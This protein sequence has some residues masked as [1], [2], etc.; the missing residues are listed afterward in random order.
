MLSKLPAWAIKTIH[1]LF[2]VLLVFGGLGP[3][4][5][6]LAGIVPAPAL[7]VVMRIVGVCSGIG[8]WI[9]AHRIPIEAFLGLP[10]G[11]LAAA[12]AKAAA[13]AVGVV[14]AL[15]VVLALYLTGCT[16]MAPIVPQTPDNAAQISSCQ[17]LSGAHND[18]VV[19]GFV[20]GLS[21]STLA[22]IAAGEAASNPSLG[23]DLGIAATATGAVAA[24]ALV[25]GSYYANGYAAQRC[26]DVMGPLPI[27]PAKTKP[28]DP[29]TVTIVKSGSVQ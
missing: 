11:T 24:G 9:A 7:A 27:L 14:S 8:L 2:V 29:V 21:G 6:K 15:L 10:P 3:E 17:S 20:V 16:P 12:R 23:R 22:G 18:F 19:G 4:L 1:I 26:P 25:L 5:G 13:A 28:A